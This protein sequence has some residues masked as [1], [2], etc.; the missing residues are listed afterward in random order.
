MGALCI[1]KTSSPLK[2]LGQ[3]ITV[4]AGSQSFFSMTLQRGLELSI[5]LVDGMGHYQY[6]QMSWALAPEKK[7]NRGYS[8]FGEPR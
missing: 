1:A 2:N 3:G 8:N 4:L 6:F 5:V 7:K